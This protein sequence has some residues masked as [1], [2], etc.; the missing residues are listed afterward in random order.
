MRRGAA[1]VVHP[2]PVT[3]SLTRP[4]LILNRRLVVG[5][6]GDDIFLKEGRQAEGHGVDLDM[7][8]GSQSESTGLYADIVIVL[9]Q[10][11]NRTCDFL[12]GVYALELLKM[13]RTSLANSIGL[14]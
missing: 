9:F 6:D 7:E 11:Q 4:P 12:L 5:D 1:S 13:R 2:V 8:H 3:E 14:S 10:S